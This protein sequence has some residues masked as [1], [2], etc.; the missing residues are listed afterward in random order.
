MKSQLQRTA[1]HDPRPWLSPLAA[2]WRG[3]LIGLLAVAI[4]MGLVHDASRSRKVARE[5]RDFA[6]FLK[7]LPA[8]KDELC[9]CW[10]ISMPLE[11]VAPWDNMLAWKN[12]PLFTLVWTQGTPWLEDTKKRFGISSIAK[13]MYTDPRV[14]TVMRQEEQGLYAQF[15]REH[16]GDRVQFVPQA[17][18]GERLLAGKFQ[19]AQQSPPIA[20]KPTSKR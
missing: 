12:R 10:R 5:R 1:H 4:G 14:L 18:A 20:E 2:R 17:R 8:T 15:V 11:L 3:A 9:V 19:A 13:A 16:Y 7:D 6:L